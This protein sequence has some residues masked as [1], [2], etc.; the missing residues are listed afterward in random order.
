M[1][2]RISIA[3]LPFNFMTLMCRTA[4]TNHISIDQIQLNTQRN[5]FYN[6]K[7]KTFVQI[8]RA[9]YNEMIC[10]HK[11][12]W[13]TRVWCLEYL[14]WLC[15]HL[16]Q[17]RPLLI[18]WNRHFWHN[19]CAIILYVCWKVL[20]Q[21]RIKDLLLKWLRLIRIYMLCARCT[22]SEMYYLFHQKNN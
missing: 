16:R 4:W 2:D 15:A 6:F 9:I 3:F 22:I 5:P 7:V 8:K 10:A 17:R 11:S 14:N 12:T 18:L 21:D 19:A 13:I 20:T 1:E